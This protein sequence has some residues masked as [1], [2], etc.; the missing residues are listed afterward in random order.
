M[1]GERQFRYKISPPDSVGW[2]R[3]VHKTGTDR[4][5]SI[6]SHLRKQHSVCHDIWAI[7]T[8]PDYQE[9]EK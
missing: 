9:E 3:Q 6:V 2:V 1:N 8:E 5:R 4:G 7:N